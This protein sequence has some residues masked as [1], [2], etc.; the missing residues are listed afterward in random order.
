M[1]KKLSGSSRPGKLVRVKA[2]DIFG[3]PLSKQQQEMLNRLAARPESEIDYSDIPPLTDEQ[4]AQMI[5]YR[6]RTKTT[7][8]S[9]RIQIDVLEWLKSKGPGHLTRINAILANV[10]EAERRLKSA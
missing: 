6:M 7:P 1:A 3:K 5:P 10:M 9:F 4:L 8:V 2:E